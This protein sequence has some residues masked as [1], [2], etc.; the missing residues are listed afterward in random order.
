MLLLHKPCYCRRAPGSPEASLKPKSTTKLTGIGHQINAQIA[1]PFSN[2]EQAEASF[3]TGLG[4][5]S[6]PIAS[7]AR[8]PAMG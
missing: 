3:T 2:N 6:P 8:M 5:L 7:S 4:E 1:Y